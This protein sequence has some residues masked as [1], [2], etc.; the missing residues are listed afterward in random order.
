M[1][2]Q[3][4]ITLHLRRYSLQ[5][6]A[7]AEWPEPWSVVVGATAVDA[8]ADGTADATAG[9]CCG[10]DI[11]RRA[12]STEGDGSAPEPRPAKWSRIDFKFK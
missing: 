2:K 6:S 4:A 3:R 9:D 12:S 5:I 1:A 11:G 10:Q 8:I 7:T